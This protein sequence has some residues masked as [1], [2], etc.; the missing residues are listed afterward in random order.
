MSYFFNNPARNISIPL[1]VLVD[2][3]VV[4]QGRLIKGVMRYT[5][6]DFAVESV[7]LPAETLKIGSAPGQVHP[8]TVRML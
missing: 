5:G 1:G 2:G 7:T 8:D 4:G 3:K 6:Y